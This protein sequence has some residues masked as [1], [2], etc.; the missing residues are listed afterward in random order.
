[1]FLLVLLAFF[2]ARPLLAQKS[3]KN[4]PIQEVIFNKTALEEIDTDYLE[5]RPLIS[6]DGNTLYFSRRKGGGSGKRKKDQDIYVAHK[7]PVDGNWGEAERLGGH[8]NNKR[9]NAVAGVNPNGKELV[10]FNTYKKTENVPLVRTVRY[11]GSWSAPQEIHI[12][13]YENFSPYSD[14]FLDFKQGVLLMAI[15]PYETKGE[16]DLFISFPD[17]VNGWTKPL[18]MGPVVNSE[19][20]DFA[21]FMGSDGRTLFFSSYGHY[22]Q[23]GSDIFMSV[24]LDDSWT[25]WSVPVNLGPQ[26][27]TVGDENYFSID[28]DFVN[29]YFSS[30]KS[31]E[32]SGPI[33]KVALPEDFTAINGPVLANLKEE[34]IQIIMDSGNFEVSPNGRTTNSEGVAFKSWQKEVASVEPQSKPPLAAPESGAVGSMPGRRVPKERPAAEVKSLISSEAAA[35]LDYLQRELPGIDFS[36]SLK[37]DTTE[38]KLVQDILYDFNSIYVGGEYQHRLNIIANVLKNRQD[39]KVQLIGHTDNIGS[40]K[41]NERVARLRVD[42]VLLYLAGRGVSRSRVEVIGAGR[43]KPVA[44]NVSAGGRRLNR[45][46]ETIIRLIEN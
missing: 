22:T 5:I 3:L 35:V 10:L 36:I 25:N 28:Q 43:S 27:N 44:P 12:Q 39:L 18:N 37:G 40:E 24:R 41:A 20:A 9:W 2:A 23:G 45:R 42:N 26:I 11:G 15:Q 1:M 7:N 30:Q 46:V 4:A 16:Q 34:E 6:A 32:A 33:M 17:G 38:Y 31:G 29:L 19:A 14:F 13:E 8:L 21:P